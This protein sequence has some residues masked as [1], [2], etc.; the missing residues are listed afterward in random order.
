MNN[1][2]KNCACLWTIKNRK[3]IRIITIKEGFTAGLENLD[4]YIEAQFKLRKQNKPNNMA[5][6]S[7]YLN[8]PGNT[9]EAF[10]I[11]KKVFKSEFINGIQR[12]GDLPS[13]PNHPPIAE[14]VK[15]M[16]LHI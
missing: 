14:A 3:D 15:K 11:Y 9:E 12:F 7:T 2:L 16:V 1:L 10:T 4:Q 5:R 13:D 8:F 6:V